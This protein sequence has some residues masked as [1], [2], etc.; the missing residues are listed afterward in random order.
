LITPPISLFL[1]AGPKGD[2]VSALGF[3]HDMF[4]RGIPSEKRG[5]VFTHFT[6][7]TDSGNIKK[8]F[9]VLKNQILSSYMSKA[10][11]AA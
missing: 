5:K 1:L 4:I 7:A 11:H 9:E 6:C 2:C 3:M 10:L 8:I